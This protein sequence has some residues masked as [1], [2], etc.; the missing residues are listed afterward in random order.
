MKIKS[1]T[2]GTQ[3]QTLDIEVADTHSY[4]LA[5]GVVTHNTTSLVVG[6]SSGIHAWHNDYYIRRM[7]VGKNEPLYKYMKEHLPEL[8]EDCKFKPHI[9]AVMSFPQKAPENAIMRTEKY[10]HLL[11][12]VK[13]FNE[14][15]VATGHINGD[16]NH[17]VSCTIS[18]KAG[19]WINCGDW[20]W[21]NRDSYNGISVLP[22]DG[23][24]YVQAPFE[25]CTKEKFEELYKLLE[26]INL[27]DVMEVEDNTTLTD[28]A[29]C[30]G[31]A[32]EVK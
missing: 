20:M 12:R 27:D 5:N 26:N 8:V 28:Q 6:S 13:K 11:K 24:T 25:D 22:Y 31:G 30:S 15:W 4:Q 32:C 14:E 17:N 21:N 23:G 29:A 3:R 1:I 19:E 18:L 7:R 10:K 9:E 2:K 16:N